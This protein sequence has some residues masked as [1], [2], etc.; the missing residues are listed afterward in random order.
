MVVSGRFF[1][2]LRAIFGLQCVMLDKLRE[3]HTFSRGATCQLMVLCNRNAVHDLLLQHGFHTTWAGGIRIS[4]VSSGAGAT[5]RVAVVV[6]T[7]WV[8]EWRM[9]GRVQWRQGR[10]LRQSDR[11]PDKDYPV[12]VHT[13]PCWHGRTARHGASASCLPHRLLHTLSP[14]SPRVCARNRAQGLSGS[15][16]VEP[17]WALCAKG[18]SSSGHSHDD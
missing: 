7:W 15:V 16:G 10:L 17:A 8:S 14:W 4:S 18:S 3:R 12:D 13:L 2:T 9:Q 5:V 6:Q 11:C 1:G